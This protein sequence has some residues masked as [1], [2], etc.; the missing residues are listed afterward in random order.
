MHRPVPPALLA[1]AVLLA[2]PAATAAGRPA[3]HGAAAHTLRLA[4]VPGQFA[5]SRTR[6]TTTAGTVTLRMSNPASFSHGIAIS[7]RGVRR[8]GPIVGQGGTSRLTARLARGTYTFFCPV[9]GHRAQGMR[10]TLT[11]R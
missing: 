4:A 11:V 1:A 9:S 2:L 3:A 10:G 6:L 7:G 8:S 5:F